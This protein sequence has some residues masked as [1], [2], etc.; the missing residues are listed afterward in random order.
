MSTSDDGG[1]IS[2]WADL[3]LPATLQAFINNPQKVILGAV[4]SGMLEWV[5]GV[6]SIGIDVILL[7][8]AGS[9]PATFDAPGEQLGI[10]DIPVSI[11]NNLGGVGGTV[12]TAIISGVEAFNAPL[13]EAAAFAGP[14][15]PIIL[16]VIIIGET[17]AVLW[18][19]QR[20]VYVAADLL[21]LGGLTE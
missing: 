10:A 14:A 3:S 2:G 12:G 16:V 15:S 19:L 1:G 4:L 8:I 6:V 13:F 11:A 17:A 18:L 20:A 5:F 7:V 9:E 21:Q